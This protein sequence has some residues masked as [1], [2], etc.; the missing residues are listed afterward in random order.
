M[1]LDGTTRGSVAKFSECRIK[2]PDLALPSF[3]IPMIF[4]FLRPLKSFWARRTL[5]IAAFWKVF[6]QFYIAK[7]FCD[8]TEEFGFASRNLAT[9]ITTVFRKTFVEVALGHSGL[10][11]FEVLYFHDLQE[12]PQGPFGVKVEFINRSTRFRGHR[13]RHRNRWGEGPKSRAAAISDTIILS[14]PRTHRPMREAVL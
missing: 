7:K 8:R 4:N 3:N 6:F 2:F 11:D 9:T 10:A 5:P 12:S 1:I 13:Q 14:N